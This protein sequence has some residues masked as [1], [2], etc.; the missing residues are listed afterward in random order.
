MMIDKLNATTKRERVCVAEFL[1]QTS[2]EKF[3]YTDIPESN[4]FY[5]AKLISVD[6]RHGTLHIRHI[7]GD[8]KYGVMC[9]EIG[10]IQ[11]F[12]W[13]SE[14]KSSIPSTPKIVQKTCAV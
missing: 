9:L 4:T 11:C 7:N 10:K 3:V 13:E 6:R 2:G 12:P 1:P 5:D 14:S 8:T